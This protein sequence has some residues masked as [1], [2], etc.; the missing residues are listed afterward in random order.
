LNAPLEHDDG[1]CDGGGDA[2]RQQRLVPD[3]MQHV[4]SRH[5]QRREDQ[6]D[7]DQIRFHNGEDINTHLT[8]AS[9]KGFIN[10]GLRIE[11]QA[12]DEAAA[13]FLIRNPQLEEF[14]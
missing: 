14:V 2:R 9:R 5:Q 6:T 11:S 4:S 1:E 12:D 7:E 10:Y 8:G 13:R 3:R